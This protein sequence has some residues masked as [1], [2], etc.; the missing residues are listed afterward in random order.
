MKSIIYAL[1]EGQTSSQLSMDLIQA[2]YAAHF[3][4]FGDRKL[5]LRIG[6]VEPNL[7]KLHTYGCVT[8]Y[9]PEGEQLSDKSNELNHIKLID[10][11]RLK[12][13]QF[14]HGAARDPENLWPE[15]KSLLIES[16]PSEETIKVGRLFNQN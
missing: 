9:N 11:T 6:T 7:S 3:F 1:P 8:A 12:N 16:L 4:V 10:W 15:E 14:K 5:I 2:Y 13:L